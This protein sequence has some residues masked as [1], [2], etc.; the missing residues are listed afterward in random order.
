M[1]IC[2]LSMQHVINF[3]SVLQA[4][5]LKKLLEE[6]GHE[7][8]FIEIESDDSF[9][10]NNYIT[11]NEVYNKRVRKLD[12]YFFN[13]VIFRIK[14]H[15]QV[16]V[17]NYFQKNIL[18]LDENNNKGKYD[19]CI[20]G[21]DEVFNCMQKSRWNFSSQLFGNI[22]QS[23]NIITFA[24]SC[25]S[26]EYDLVPKALIPIIRESMNRI[27]EFSVRDTNTY[28]F[29]YKM[30]GKKSIYNLDPVVML[31]QNPHNI[32][33]IKNNKYCIIY[34]YTNRICDKDLIGSI[35]DYCKT[36][37]IE[38]ISVFGSQF[39]SDSYKIIDPLD[40]AGLFKYS[41]F[42][43]TDTFH[44]TIFSFKYAKKFGILIRDSNK[45]KL[46]DLIARLGIED[47][48]IND[49]NDIIT[50]LH[51]RI[52]YEKINKIEIEAYN[53]AQKYINLCIN[54]IQ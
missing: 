31:I 39:W 21:S 16:K 4:F 50:V 37:K 38:I 32:K 29:V 49:L 17:L 35:K 20:I 28:E 41:E 19:L 36:N 23:D 5:S 26:T 42:V 46:S 54:Q 14:F 7:V 43:I 48:V 1:K 53:E 15:R 9:D 8:K 30:T 40:I 3:G 13:R 24:A 18:K 10:I 27:T 45:N 47:H 52:D 25:G 12:K 44:G 34:S 22:R 6:M 2:I 51:N 11:Q 33:R